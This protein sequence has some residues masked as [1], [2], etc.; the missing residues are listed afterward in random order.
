MMVVAGM[1]RE[2]IHV[3]HLSIIPIIAKDTDKLFSGKLV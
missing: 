1:S 3:R 2:L